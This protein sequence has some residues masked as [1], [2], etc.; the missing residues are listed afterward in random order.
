MGLAL[1]LDP[2]LSVEYVAARERKDQCRECSQSCGIEGGV[3][4]HPWQL[5]GGGQAD[6]FA[7]PEVG[8]G[9]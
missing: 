6:P 5:Y 9:V 7:L 1:V 3:E 4:A 2:V 8:G